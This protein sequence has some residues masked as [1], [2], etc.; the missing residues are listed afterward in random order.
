[1]LPALASECVTLVKDSSLASI[2]GVMELYKEAQSIINQSYDVI[3]IFCMV[4]FLYLAMTMVV[5]MFFKYV[6][7]KMDWY[8][9]GN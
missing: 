1:M 4:A 2:I 3:S 7:R 5:A 6:E 8:V 9:K